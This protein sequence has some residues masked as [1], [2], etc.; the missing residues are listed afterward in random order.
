M[1]IVGQK[2]NVAFEIE[3]NLAGKLL[4]RVYSFW[5]TLEEAVDF[6]LIYE[7]REDFKLKQKKA[8]LV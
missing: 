6:G 2:F 8:N 5:A 4:Q 7:C 1:R 3:Q